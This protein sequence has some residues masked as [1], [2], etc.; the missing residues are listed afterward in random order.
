MPRILYVTGFPPFTRAKDLAHE[1]EKYGKLI[2]ADIP[3]MKPGPRSIPYAFVEYRSDRD[4]EAAYKDMHGHYFDGVRL[5][6]EWARKAPSSSWR[7]N[8]PRSSS[9]SPRRR[10]RSPYRERAYNRDRER[11]YDRERD[12]DK[13]RDRE[14]SRS[15]PPRR[16]SGREE[17]NGDAA[18]TGSR[19]D[20]G[21]E[22]NR[23]ERY[24]HRQR[25]Q[26]DGER[27]DTPDRQQKKGHRA[28][29][30]TADQQHE[31]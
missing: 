5:R 11:V 17:H 19:R 26:R 30:P 28:G 6:I 23:E 27:E 10:S 16:E 7:Y 20:Y 21:R 18:D 1:F 12:R 3:A 14:R 9:N 13:G 4:A 24:E 2:R 15:P 29:T 31:G 22:R 25:D 8:D